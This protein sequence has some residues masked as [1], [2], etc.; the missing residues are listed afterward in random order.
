MYPFDTLGSVYEAGWGTYDEAKTGRYGPD[1]YSKCR[2]P[3]IFQNIK[4]FGCVK[5]PSPTSLNKLCMDYY[6]NRNRTKLLE[7]GFDRVVNT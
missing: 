6:E 3:F 2:F 5:M 1:P 7:K 4:L